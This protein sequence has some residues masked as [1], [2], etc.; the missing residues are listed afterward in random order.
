MESNY[1]NNLRTHYS[2][3]RKNI[4][5][6]TSY[7]K[8]FDKNKFLINENN[9]ISNNKTIYTGIGSPINNITE[10]YNSPYNNYHYKKKLIDLNESEY[11][12]SMSKIDPFYFQDIIKSIEND[13]IN[14]KVK[15]VMHLQREAIKQ[16][17]LLKIRNPSQKEK[18][19]KINE[20][21]PNPMVSYEPKHPFYKKTLDKYYYNEY[22]IKKNYMN[23][24]PKPR[25]EIEDYY[26]IC[27]YQ[28]SDDTNNDPIIHTKGNYIYPNYGKNK[29]GNKIIEEL[30]K[31]I[32]IKRK[33]K[34][35]EYYED[36]KNGIIMNKIYKNHE[37]FLLNKEKEEKLDKQKEINIDN[38]ILDYY[39]EYEKKHLHDGEKDCMAKIRKKMEEEDFLKKYEEKRA[40]LKT[41]KNLREWSEINEKIKHNKNNDKIKEKK[42][43]RNY[44]EIYVVKCKHGNELYR[45]CRCGNHYTRDQMHKVIY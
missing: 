10:Q 44:S 17:S 37:E 19:Q 31:Q 35:N 14:E 13:K 28:T 6:F 32:E 43:M 20:F 21:S 45:C 25:K 9:T 41:M 18:L 39:K 12:N 29:N 4:N 11:N 3:K 38:F 5:C 42:I 34:L 22:L 1:Q 2:P 36:K 26:N 15:N 23:I 33:S 24:Y 40:K 8:T 27:Q 7:N 30:D 16:L